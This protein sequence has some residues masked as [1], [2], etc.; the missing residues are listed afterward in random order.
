MEGENTF[1]SSGGDGFIVKWDLNSPEAPGKVIA[2][3]G[4]VVYSLLFLSEKNQLI[5][6]TRS[7][8]IFLFDLA[9]NALIKQVKAEGEVFSIIKSGNNIIAGSAAGNLY[10]FDEDL[11]LTKDLN[12]SEKSCR[13]IIALNETS[14]ATG[15]SDNH[16]RIFDTP[17]LQLTTSFEAHSTSVFSLAFIRGKYLLSGGRD[18]RLKIWEMKDYALMLEIPAHWFAINDIKLSPDGKY[19]AT[20]SR[21]KTVKIWDAT[22]FELLKVLDNERSEGH[23]HSVNTLLWMNETTL[24]SAGDDRKIDCWKIS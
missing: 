1:F 16:I 9:N 22:T 19:F 14:I 21:D 2:Q 6:G 3:L 20:A 17:G 24:L 18:A 5:A 15:W 12:V 7:G 10:L 11:N 23:T 13:C 4:S 8:E